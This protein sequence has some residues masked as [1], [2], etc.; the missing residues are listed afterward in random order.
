MYYPLLVGVAGI[1][2][3]LVVISFFFRINSSV[4]L[5]ALGFGIVV[6]LVSW[7]W[8]AVVGSKDG[9]PWWYFLPR[10]RRYQMEVLSEY[11]RRNPRRAGTAFW[12]AMLGASLFFLTFALFLIREKTGM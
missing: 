10:F 8:L 6:C 1:W 12:L 11:A 9:L 4:G 7:L 3:M 2:L 5:A